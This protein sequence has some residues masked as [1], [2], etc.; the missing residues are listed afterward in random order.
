MYSTG[1]IANKGYVYGPDGLIPADNSD[2][3]DCGHPRPPVEGF[4]VP[5]GIVNTPDGK[6]EYCIECCEKLEI[7]AIEQLPPGAV[8]SA[9]YNLDNREITTWHGTRLMQIVRHNVYYHNFGGRFVSIGAI[10]PHGCYWHGRA[11]ASFECINM[12]KAKEG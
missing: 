6:Q 3:L 9:Y 7:A 5:W 2:T 10:D 11:S 12:H 4:V 8:Y 1:L